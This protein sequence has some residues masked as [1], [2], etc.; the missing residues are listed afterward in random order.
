MVGRPSCVPFE[1][2]H[3]R[4]R[5]QHTTPA[6]LSFS[7]DGLLIELVLLICARSLHEHPLE[8]FHRPSSFTSTSWKSARGRGRAH[9][10]ADDAKAE[11]LAS[12][13]DTVPGTL[14]VRLL[15]PHADTGVPFLPPRTLRGA[16]EN[17]LRACSP[18]N[19]QLPPS[20]K[21]SPSMTP[22]AIANPRLTPPGI[23]QRARRC[24]SCNSALLMA[25]PSHF[26][27]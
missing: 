15:G 18:S 19:S 2:V 21:F 7:E 16:Q 26:A 25:W 5:L 11:R 12:A 14:P 17:S 9:P 6:R 4:L 8:S 22:R 27:T 13:R 1:C 24:G 20:F 3:R 10:N 23:A